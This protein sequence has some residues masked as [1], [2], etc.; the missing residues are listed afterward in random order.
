MPYSYYG[1]N[2]QYSGKFSRGAIFVD[3]GFEVFRVLI[4]EDQAVR[5]LARYRY[6]AWVMGR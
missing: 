2:I 4:F 1:E 3:V 5:A 6:M